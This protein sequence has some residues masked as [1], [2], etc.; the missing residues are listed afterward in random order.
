MGKTKILQ[1]SWG[2]SKDKEDL[3]CWILGPQTILKPA[4]NSMGFFLTTALL[5]GG[6]ICD[7]P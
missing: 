1:K 6:H 2:I 3:E 7:S 4:F 5:T